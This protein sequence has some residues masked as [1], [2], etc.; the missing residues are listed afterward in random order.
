MRI[1]LPA[2]LLGLLTVSACKKQNA[3][4][5]P[6][7][8]E[9]GVVHPD[10]RIIH[11][12][13][14]ATGQVV[15][16]NQ[17]DVAARVQGVVQKIAYTDG[18]P[19]KAGQLLF[20][21]EPAPYEAKLQQ[22]QA[23]LA[24][25]EAQY[26]Q[27]SAEYSRQA[28]LGRSDFSSRSAVDQAKAARDADKANVANQQAAVA[29]A[30]INLGY[31]RVTAPFD[32]IATNHLVSVGELV[33]VTGPTKLAAVVQLDPIYVNFTASEQEVQ[34]LHAALAQR[35][36]TVAD[37]GT[38]SVRIGLMTTPGYTL[39]GT[40]DYISP[41]VDPSTGTLALRAV[42]RN[43]AHD[44][45]PGYFVRVRV[46]SDKLAE[47]A[48]LVPAVALGADQG[49]RYVLVVN[50]QDVVEERHVKLGQQEGALRV[51]TAGLT[52]KD[53]VIVTGLEHAIPGAK[54]TPKPAPPPAS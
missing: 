34:M 46:T 3:Y 1:T 6:P 11:P 18:T 32:G 4:V 49:G 9:V 22:A 25:A 20:L 50:K 44:L 14:D 28:S 30:S 35:H 21:I 24:A 42:V 10:S 27:A 29:L 8:A 12:Y 13:L 5:A 26:A 16:Y 39:H 45:L 47:P 2:V 53:A 33:G 7:R 36:L 48:L 51:V 23:S 17:V 19:V 38:T 52:P 41:V 54:V 40:L 37:L 43:P 31:T 15:A